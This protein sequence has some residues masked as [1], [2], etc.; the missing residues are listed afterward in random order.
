[1][2]AASPARSRTISRLI[3]ADLQRQG[4]IALHGRKL[5]VPDLKALQDAAQF[6]STY[7][8]LDHEGRQFD[9]GFS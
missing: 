8:H 4:L 9:A 3:C 1:M 2:G 5:T 6:N 7:L